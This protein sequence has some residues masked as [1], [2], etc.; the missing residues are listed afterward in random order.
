MNN[1]PKPCPVHEIT[2]GENGAKHGTDGTVTVSLLDEGGKMFK[3]RAVKGFGTP[4][5]YEECWLVVE[6][7]GV[8]V[9]QQ[10]NHVV[11]TTNDL[12]P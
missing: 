10:G 8:R 9:Y 6:L 1:L 11:V 3:R 2:D 12:N 7:N 4:E 5:S